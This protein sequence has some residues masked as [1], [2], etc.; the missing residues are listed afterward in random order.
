MEDMN[1]GGDIYNNKVDIDLSVSLNPCKMPDEIR[2]A[3]QESIDKA[4][5]YPDIRQEALRE[6]LAGYLKLER[7]MVYFGNGASEL[8]MS[9]VRAVKPKKALLFEPCFSGYERAL[10]SFGCDVASHILN[11]ENGFKIGRDDIKAL[12]SDTDILFLC[13]PSNPAG[14]NLDED[15]LTELLNSA[16]KNKATVVLDESFYQMSE[17]YKKGGEERSRKLLDEYEDLY[18]VRSFTKLF[19]MPG[20]RTGFVLSSPE[21]IKALISKLPEWNISVT[22]AE[23]AKAGIR[24]LS[25]GEFLKQTHELISKE[26][27]H[28]AEALNGFGFTVFE[29]DTCFILFKGP[30]ELYPALLERGILIRDCS[31][32]KGLSK[33]SY[34]TGVRDASDNER[35]ISAVKGVLD[36]IH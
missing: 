5:F 32:F 23:A 28:L 15:I 24:L 2:R 33:G 12:S 22:S 29:S 9:V 6:E 17:G 11:E 36:G 30:E 31:S 20:I 14:C 10:K 27:E 16:K 4:Q 34:R 3:L 26:R 21:N 19:A 7:D 25:E 18:I 8:L 13:D 35:F 1:H